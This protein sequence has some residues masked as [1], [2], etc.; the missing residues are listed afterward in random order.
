MYWENQARINIELN[1]F[2]FIWYAP[3]HLISPELYAK[4]YTHTSNGIPNF[5][6]FKYQFLCV[7]AFSLLSFSPFILSALIAFQKKALRF[8]R[9]KFRVFQ[10]YYYCN[11][12]ITIFS[13]NKWMETLHRDQNEWQVNARW[14]T[15]QMAQKGTYR[16][17]HKKASNS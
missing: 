16:S 9:A 10:Y 13:A 17:Y 7:R 15:E 8:A 1:A 6:T 3:A 5:E 2:D 12:V 14:S 4:L 11:N